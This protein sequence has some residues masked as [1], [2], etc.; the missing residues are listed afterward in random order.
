MSQAYWDENLTP[1]RR[2]PHRLPY[3]PCMVYVVALPAQE[4]DRIYTDLQIKQS[5]TKTVAHQPLH[6]T[7]NGSVSLWA[8]SGRAG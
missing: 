3:P 5:F 1:T 4:L 7:R 2:S 8:G 6:R